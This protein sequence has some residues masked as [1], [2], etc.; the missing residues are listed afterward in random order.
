MERLRHLIVIV[1]GIGGSV[2]VT[3][4]EA[5]VWGRGRRHLAA[6][7]AWPERLSLVEHPDLVP[8]DVVPA[9]RVLPWIVIHGYDSL[10]RKIQKSFADVRVDV[11]RPGRD[12]DL[13]ASVMVF[14]YDFRRGIRQTADRLGAEVG[15]RLAGLTASAQ[16]RRVIVV[17]H[18]MGGLV[19]RYWLGPLGGAP[20]CRALITVGTPHSGAPKALDWLINGPR[21]GPKTLAKAT[22]MLRG[23]D[24]A[25]ELLPT[26]HAVLAPGSAE[27]VRVTE[28]GALLADETVGRWFTP[29]ARGA[30]GMHEEIA[31]SWTALAG[32]RDL[33]EVI[34]LFG[35]GH[36]TAN[37][38]VLRDGQ[39]VVTKD[40]AEWGRNVGWRGD[41]TVPA[42]DSLP[43]EL[44]Q[45]RGS[46]RAMP[47]R[48]QPMATATEI[49]EILRTLE[50]ESIAA[51]GMD[52]PP[53]PWLGLDLDELTLADTSFPLAAQLLGA[54]QSAAAAVE[55]LVAPADGTAAPARYPMN[56]GAGWWRTAV[57]PLPPGAY[58]VKVEAVGVPQVDRVVS[59]DVIGVVAE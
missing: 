32:G 20:Y 48:H 34:P 18:S 6:T 14:P 51:R 47:Q 49:I 56:Y 16:R 46:W 22:A 8:V 29:R 2:L 27:A 58:R 37:R 40:D 7:L 17:A 41:G 57:G 45:M 52:R 12:P 21:A 9:T 33:P 5:V 11:A 19:A 15:S 31:D 1:P 25:Y 28:I 38:A 26:Y 23:W 42:N 36:P 3:R 55:A 10:I 44:D 53:R 50:G 43:V 4:D 30:L 13:A 59:E 35:R 24:S 39:L 54:P